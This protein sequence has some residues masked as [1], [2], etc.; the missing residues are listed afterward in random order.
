MTS[1]EQLQETL[2]NRLFWHTA[3]RDDAK[4][5]DYL[6]HRHEMDI[7]YAMDEA[8]LFDSFF[9]YL[10]SIKQPN[11]TR[12]QTKRFKKALEPVSLWAMRPKNPAFLYS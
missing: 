10:T 11:P 7:V 6:F 3:E 9:N 5:A 12:R 2:C 1:R 4:V 8:A